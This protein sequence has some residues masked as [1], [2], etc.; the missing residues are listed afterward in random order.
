MQLSCFWFAPF[1]K[2]HKGFLP[3]LWS[4][5][6]FRRSSRL[7][8]DLSYNAVFGS[9]SVLLI[10]RENFSLSTIK[11]QALAHCNWIFPFTDYRLQCNL[12]YAILIHFHCFVPYAI[13]T[14]LKGVSCLKFAMKSGQKASAIL[15]YCYF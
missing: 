6:L 11:K 14:Q 5:N 15:M 9:I 7:I 1:L 12:T 3:T 2:L 13:C 4:L 10:C 8:E